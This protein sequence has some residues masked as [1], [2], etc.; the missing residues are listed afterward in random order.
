MS[1]AADNDGKHAEN[2][3]VVLCEG[4]PKLWCLRVI[5][6]N[7]LVHKSLKWNGTQD[8]SSA[9]KDGSE[10]LKAVSL[11]FLVLKVTKIKIVKKEKYLFKKC[12]S[13][14]TEDKKW[15]KV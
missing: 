10:Q 11:S 12:N 13:L 4:K 9:A 15:L 6:R 3:L 2:W 8:H 5:E 7:Y 14:K 1:S